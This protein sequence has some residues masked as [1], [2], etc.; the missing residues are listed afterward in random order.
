MALGYTSRKFAFHIPD[1]VNV[2]L[3][4]ALW[5]LM[6]FL[7]MGL[8]FKK[9]S[10]CKTALLATI[11]CYCIEI[12]QLYHAPWIDAIRD[13]KLGGLVFGFGFLW[14]DIL[15]Y[16]MG[17]AW[18]VLHEWLFVYFLNKSTNFK[19]DAQENR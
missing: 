6:V 9:S 12:S 14:T 2:Y 10:I 8:L 15:A 17:I 3:G 1:F 19:L 11:F 4:D 16:S 7:M 5:A 18:G 13:T